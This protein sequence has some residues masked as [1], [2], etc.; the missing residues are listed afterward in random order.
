MQIRLFLARSTIAACSFLLVAGCGGQPAQDD[1]RAAEAVPTSNF[2]V[3]TGP[4]Y[5]HLVNNK[6]GSWVFKTITTSD[7]P[8][9]SAY[10][11]RL[12]DLTPA[13]D[14]R[15]AEC[16]PQ[17]YPDVHRCNP[18]NP[19]RDEDSGML[20]KIINGTI[21]V[22]T[23]GKVTD[24]TYAYETTFDETDFNRAVDEALL[25]TDLDRRRLISLV[26]TYAAEV[27]DA[28]A[29]LQAATEQLQALRAS[30]NQVELDIQPSISGLLEYYQDDIDFAQLIDLEIAGDAPP[31]A[32]L[33][34]P[35]ILPCDARQC[36][37]TADA[38]LAAL[39][40]NVQ[41]NMEHVAAGTRPHSRTYRVRCDAASYGDYQL[42]VECPAEVV[43]SDEQPVQ[44]PLGVTI[45]SRDFD[46]LYP[47]FGIADEQLRVAI[48]GRVVTFFN[49]TS[50]YLT[51]SA[52][53]VYYNSQVHTIAIPIEIPPGI[54]VTRDVQEFVSQSIDIESTYRQM[55]P[56]K[57][58]GASFQFGFA[59]RYR[60][61]SRPEEQT[62]HN[63]HAF[64]VGCVIKNR[65]RP[66][67]CQPETVADSREPGETAVPSE[68][69]FGPM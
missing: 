57:A 26:E 31:V 17:V 32:K 39:R 23:A 18:A 12:N 58:A 56:D 64:N 69:R 5:A 30:T 14:T 53:T 67:S 43:A 54:S 9:E 37:A 6:G 35:A 46:G 55:T 33:E 62:L 24:I 59:V 3:G 25:N 42:R 47:A 13:F 1:G 2:F 34:A 65:V 15:V 19:F 49:T 51:V 44:L 10:L 16:T 48:D 7:E 27:R 52:Q 45:L 38:A 36:I 4:V 22:G 50:E 11:V 29:R 60:L 61:A 8:P 28:R 41:T 68:R 63:L 21:A 40:H 20:D 66:M